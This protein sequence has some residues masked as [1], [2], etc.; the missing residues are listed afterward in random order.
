MILLG[1]GHPKHGR[2]AVIGR[3]GEGA[4]I[5]LEHLLGQSHHRL[6]QAI[7][8]LRAQPRRQGGRL[9]QR[10]AE[11]GDQLVFS[12]GVGRGGTSGV[13][14]KERLRRMRWR[15]S[16]RRRGLR[17]QSVPQARWGRR[18]HRVLHLD[19]RHNAIAAPAHGAQ[20]PLAVPVIAKRLADVPDVAIERR[21][22]HKLAWPHMF[23]QFLLE[24]HPVSMRQ[25]IGQHLIH[26]GPQRNGHAAPVQLIALG[27]ET[28]V[29]KEIAHRPRLRLS[30]ETAVRPGHR[31]GHA[32]YH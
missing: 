32:S 13:G 27:I 22:P 9:G 24:H 17:H 31:C 6:E 5:G 28:I 11:D 4:R 1:H 10:P 16:G 2:E 21:I 18:W 30:R 7:P 14:R 20:E 19:W 3:Q 26:L 15:W 8:P 23:E 12:L 25:E 29:A